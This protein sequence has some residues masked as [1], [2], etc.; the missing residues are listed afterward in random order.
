MTGESRPVEE[1]LAGTAHP[2]RRQL[3]LELAEGTSDSDRSPY[4]P[5][6]R[7]PGETGLTWRPLAGPTP[8]RGVS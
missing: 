5:P 4:D 2:R 1:P 8:G 6:R 7:M 3:V